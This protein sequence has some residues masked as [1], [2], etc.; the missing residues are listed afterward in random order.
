MSFQSVSE[1]EHAG[2]IDGL[3]ERPSVCEGLVIEFVITTVSKT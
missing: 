2:G 1:I 3:E